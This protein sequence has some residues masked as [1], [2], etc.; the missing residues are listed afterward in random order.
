MKTSTDS[1]RREF[2]KTLPPLPPPP[3]PLARPRSSRPACWA[4]KARRRERADHHRR[5]RRRR[6]GQ[7]ID[8]P[9]AAA[10]THRR[11]CPIAFCNERRT[12]AKKRNAK[13]AMLPRLSANV[14]QGKV[15]CRH[16]RH[17]RSCPHV[18]LHSSGAARAR[19]LRREAA[20]GLHRKRAACSSIT[21]AST[22][23]CS[24]S[25]RS[26]ERWKSIASAAS[27]SATERSA[28]SNRSRR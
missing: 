12:A 18:A 25:A 27:S 1:T 11:R 9:S 20:Y 4:A 28:R 15:G 23:A 2:L 10:R 14:R 16:H 5:H 6:P 8:R 22:S 26:S 13:W 24:K 3:R 19:R 17:A 21:C 7:S